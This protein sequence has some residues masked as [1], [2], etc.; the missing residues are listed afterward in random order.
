MRDAETMALAI[1]AAATGQLVFATLHTPSAAQSIDRILDSYD[2][3]R[4]VQVRLM[5]AESLK[6][7]IAQ[8]LLRR[9]DGGGRRLALEVLMG[10]Y[11][12]AALI[13]E[14]KTYQLP[15]VMQ[16]SRR[17][18]MQTLDDAILKLVREGTVSAEDAQVYM[19][20]RDLIAEMPPAAEA[21]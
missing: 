13:R 11:A 5:L 2:G 18:G 16:T 8:R 19:A 1:T 15:S 14:R 10:S 3:D 7:V 6:C 21:A 17:E 12:V 9:T 20:N 4:Q